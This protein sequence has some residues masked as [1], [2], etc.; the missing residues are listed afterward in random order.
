MLLGSGELGKEVAI[1]LQRLGCEVIAVD[2]YADA[3]AMQ[4]A[5]RSHVIA[6]HISGRNDRNPGRNGNLTGRCLVAKCAHGFGFGANKGDVMGC[7]GLDKIRVFGQQTVARVDRISAAFPRY[8]DNFINR[9]IGGHRAHASAN[10]VGFIGFEPVQAELVFFSE[11]RDGF[12]SHLICGS[13]DA[14]GNFSTV[15]N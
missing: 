5:H 12:L 7:A 15:G 6:K 8:A 2:R 4:V 11:D 10:A 3:P 1:E 14:N 13:H 9:Q